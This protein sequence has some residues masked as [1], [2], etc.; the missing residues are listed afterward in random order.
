MQPGLAEAMGRRIGGSPKAQAQFLG[1]IEGV[2]SPA[3]TE[4]TA[5]PGNAAGSS[6]S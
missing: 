4:V 2:R 6:S 1:R 3:V 5:S